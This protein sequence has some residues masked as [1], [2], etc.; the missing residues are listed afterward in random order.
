MKARL[1]YWAIARHYGKLPEPPVRKFARKWEA[2]RYIAQAAEIAKGYGEVSVFQ[3][4]GAWYVWEKGADH[5]RTIFYI[6]TERK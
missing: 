5:A 6:H 1:E 3:L 4:D 2:E